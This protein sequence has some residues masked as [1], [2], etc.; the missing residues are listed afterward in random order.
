MNQYSLFSSQHKVDTTFISELPSITIPSQG[1]IRQFQLSHNDVTVQLSSLGA[2]ITSILLPDYSASAPQASLDDVVLS[3][4]SP[5]EQCLHK[6]TQFFSAIVG[7]VANRIKDG[8]FQLQQQ[9]QDDEITEYN[10]DKN[11]GN[12]NHLH[13]GYEGFSHRIWEAEMDENQVKFTLTSEDGDQGYPGGIQVTAIYS[14]VANNN[15]EDDVGAKLKLQMHGCLQEGETKA[16]PI[17]LAQHSY[18]N[19]ASHSSLERILNHVLHM[20]YCD[21]FTPLD[22]TSI[23]TKEVKSVKEV[24]AMDFCEPRTISDAL[25]HYGEQMV[26]LTPEVA[27]ENIHQIAKDWSTQTIFNV[28]KEG[29]AEGSNL[30][31]DKPYGFDHNYIIG[32]HNDDNSPLRLAAVL[33]H[34]PTRRSMSVLTSA[35]GVQLY[36]SNYLSGPNPPPDLCKG[37]SKYSQWQGICLETQTFPD[38]IYSTPPDAADEFG[39]GRCFILRPGGDDYF[40]EVHFDFGRMPY[41]D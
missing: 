35:P 11:D 29:G 32:N 14:L 22:N 38:S 3:Y 23:P 41:C 5:K 6:N 26:G 36:T 31:G 40:H 1:T 8:K 10:L 16:S 7:R 33:S 24:M 13:G 9:Q 21:K 30:D 18:F 27:R 19:L 2:S 4:K 37:N 34:P 15:D 28:P 25:I 20:P 17:A 12:I 39:K